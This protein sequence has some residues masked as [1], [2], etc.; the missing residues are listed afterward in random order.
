MVTMHVPRVSKVFLYHGLC[1]LDPPELC[2]AAV[3]SDSCPASIES[4]DEFEC[5]TKVGSAVVALTSSREGP[6]DSS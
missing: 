5:V 2:V 3:W 4:T 1:P 6:R